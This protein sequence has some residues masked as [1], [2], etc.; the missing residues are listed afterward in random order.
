MS[1]LAPSLLTPCSCTSPQP[2]SWHGTGTG[3]K[4]GTLEPLPR[5]PWLGAAPLLGFLNEGWPV[6]SVVGFTTPFGQCLQEKAAGRAVAVGG[7]PVNG[8]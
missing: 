2:L 1:L 6:P 8:L 5:S 7:I 4:H 3:D